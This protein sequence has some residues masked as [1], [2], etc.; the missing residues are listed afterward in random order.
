MN[1]NTSRT[2][3]V[4]REQVRRAEQFAREITGT[5]ETRKSGSAGKIFAGLVALFLASA[6]ITGGY[7]FVKWI[8]G[9]L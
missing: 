6:A 5:M 3:Q 7:Y 1:E 2:D 8:A 4:T 9:A